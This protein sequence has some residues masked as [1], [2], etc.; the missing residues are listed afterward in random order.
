MQAAGFTVKLANTGATK[1]HDGLKHSGDQADAR[2]LAELLRLGI[3][4]TGTIL[5]AGQRAIRHLARKRMSLCESIGR[6]AAPTFF[7]SGPAARAR[8]A[9]RPALD[10]HG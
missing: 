2:H 4:P 7:W 3:L 6:E 9:Y 10:P 5:P 1:N 8:A